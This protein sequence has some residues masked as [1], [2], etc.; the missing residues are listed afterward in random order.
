MH[1]VSSGFP[2][3]ES[4]PDIGSIP[5]RNFRIQGKPDKKQNRTKR[6]MCLYLS[7]HRVRC[8][9]TLPRVLTSTHS[10]RLRSLLR[11]RCSSR[12]KAARQPIA[13]C[14]TVLAVPTAGFCYETGLSLPCLSGSLLHSYFSQTHEQAQSLLRL[15]GWKGYGC[16]VA[17]GVP[18]ICQ[19]TNLP[20]SM[21]A[22]KGRLGCFL[23]ICQ[24]ALVNHFLF[25][26]PH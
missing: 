6:K 23:A 14:S 1:R 21:A 26:S 5:T 19:M 9:S 12:S 22:L 13:R 2:A 15:W 25:R 8:Y 3:F 7:L 10:S 4:Y 16:H 17:R 20:G 18:A 24:M 11:A